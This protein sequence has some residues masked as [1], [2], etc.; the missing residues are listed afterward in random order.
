MWLGWKQLAEIEHSARHAAADLETS[1]APRTD[2]QHLIVEPGVQ[3]RLCESAI[4]FRF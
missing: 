1:N 4:D 3:H 2:S